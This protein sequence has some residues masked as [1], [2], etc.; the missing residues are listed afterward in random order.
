MEI[1]KVEMKVMKKNEMA[2]SLQNVKTEE[3]RNED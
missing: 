2:N 3:Y 1:M